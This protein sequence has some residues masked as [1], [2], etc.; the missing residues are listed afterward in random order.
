M[1]QKSHLCRTWSDPRSSCFATSKES[2]ANSTQILAGRI[3]L[4]LAR[5]M[6]MLLRDI[7]KRITNYTF[8]GSHDK[9]GHCKVDPDRMRSLR[10][11]VQQATR[12]SQSRCYRKSPHLRG[13]CLPTGGVGRS[14]PTKTCTV[15]S[16]VIEGR[17][18]C[19]FFESELNGINFCKL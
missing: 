3:I 18:L 16:S 15:H 5:D 10:F 7:S 19:V 12:S 4:G 11:V 2:P 13:H 14:K 1:L 9:T 8:L 17:L 6:R